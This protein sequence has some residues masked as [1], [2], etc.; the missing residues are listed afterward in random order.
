MVL[1]PIREIYT[2][3]WQ[4]PIYAMRQWMYGTSSDTLFMFFFLSLLRHLVRLGI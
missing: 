3:L 4:L 1:N 2:I